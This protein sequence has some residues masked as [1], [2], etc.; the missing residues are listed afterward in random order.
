MHGRLSGQVTY[1]SDAYST[2]SWQGH[3]LCSYHLYVNIVDVRILDKSPS[4]IC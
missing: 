3:C 2:T 1:V 4:P